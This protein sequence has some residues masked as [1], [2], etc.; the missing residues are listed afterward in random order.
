MPVPYKEEIKPPTLPRGHAPGSG[1]QRRQD[2]PHTLKVGKFTSPIIR[3]L[4]VAG[5]KAGP[6]LR[7][8]HYGWFERVRRGVYGLTPK[9]REALDVYALEIKVLQGVE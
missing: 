9:G 8:N 5:N 2:L 4:Y 6:I 1:S 3:E 7:D